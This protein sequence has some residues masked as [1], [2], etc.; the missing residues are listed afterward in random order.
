MKVHAAAAT[1]KSDWYTPA[2]IVALAR[3]VLGVID[4]D[5][6]SCAAANATVGA[7]R[8]YTQDDDG[9]AQSW[10]G[11]V[12]LNPPYSRSTIH[13]WCERW[14]QHDGPRLLLTNASTDAKWFH[15]LLRGAD[16]VCLTRG[17][18][19]FIDGNSGL[20]KRGNSQGQAVW[21]AGLPRDTFCNAFR[22][23]GSVLAL[24]SAPEVG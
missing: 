9:L 12:W 24:T 22:S 19:S 10:Q 4:L 1:G 6:A 17:R 2:E 23:L 13:A 18:I 14:I 21:A 11:Q 7:Q 15:A 5:P 20:R 3:N 16:A 8:Y